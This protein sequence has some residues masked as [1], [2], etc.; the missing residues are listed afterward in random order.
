MAASSRS[1]AFSP[2]QL[3]AAVDQLDP[4]DVRPFVSR[5]IARAARRIAP[6]LS[7]NETDHL[8]KI[9]QGLPAGVERRTRELVARRRAGTL[10]AKQHTELLELTEET[11]KWQAE[12]VRHLVDLARIRGTSL[13][14]LMDELGIEAPPVE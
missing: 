4:A 13:P 11:E 6:S 2:D 5:V 7:E 3:L 14:E 10:S 1:M 12:R 9:N 8:Q